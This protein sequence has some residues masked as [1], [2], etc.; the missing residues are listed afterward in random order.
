MTTMGKGSA[1]SGA[2]VPAERQR[3]PLPFGG[4]M[5]RQ[6]GVMI[7]EPSSFEYL[8][9]VHLYAGKAELRRGID[10]VSSTFQ[11]D[12]GTAMTHILAG[13]ALQSRNI[14]IIVGYES[15]GRTLHVFS[16]NGDLSGTPRY[17][18]QWGDALSVDA[19]DP[20]AIIAVE[21]NECVFLAHAEPQLFLRQ[22]TVYYDL[23][24]VS[25]KNMT[26]DWAADAG[27]D[28][29]IRFSGVMT[30]LDYLIGWGFGTNSEDH[31]EYVR[32]SVPQDQKT[33]EPEHFWMV[34]QRGVPV[35]CCAE[36][37]GGV[38]AMQK[39]RSSRLVG[40]SWLDFGLVTA[41]L[42]FG[43][44]G[45]RLAINYEGELYVWTLEGLRKT[46][47]GP[48]GDMAAPLDLRGEEP[49]DV[50]AR[51]GDIVD[52]FCYYLPRRAELIWQFGEIAYVLHLHDPNYPRLSYRDFGKSTYY[53]AFTLY[54]G[55][56]SLTPDIAPTSYPEFLSADPGSISAS[57][58]WANHG[59]AEF[60][61]IFIREAAA[62]GNPA[63]AW[64]KESTA[65]QS[66]TE[67]LYALM[68]VL[69]PDTLYDVALRFRVGDLIIPGYE[70]ADPDN[71]TDDATVD[72]TPADSKGQF[73]TDTFTAPSIDS[74]AWSRTSATAEKVHLV[75]TP[76]DSLCDIRLE[77]DGTLVTTVAAGTHGGEA[78]AVDDIS[79][80]DPTDFAG[81][82]VVH[83]VATPSYDGTDFSASGTVGQ[84]T[85]PE[86]APYDLLLTDIP[87][88]GYTLDWDMT[89]LVNG[90]EVYRDIN[91][92]SGFT[93]LGSPKAA[94]YEDPGG[95][96]G[97]KYKVRAKLHTY[98]VDDYSEFS[99]QVIAT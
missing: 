88:G 5:D 22:S 82:T 45:P 56:S 27:S 43:C 54:G 83:Y 69:Q 74:T 31:P 34:G 58:T 6:T 97:Y 47:G 96:V 75:I 26:A 37:L 3:I 49:T 33:F 76:A 62:D 13:V 73:T 19:K 86:P 36:S 25:L 72:G 67:Q 52:G 70:D 55:S 46:V 59:N 35:Q 80:G 79:D 50:K 14:G 23:A 9:N 81:E 1:Q 15:A 84:Y 94:T 89:Y 12:G 24:S 2:V 32:V 28:T 91:D 44:A 30:Y 39:T 21:G 53:C 98:T 8:W 40:T 60:V 61:D 4:G 99:S 18:Q 66:V 10:P 93:W 85:G 42:L 78:F 7:I 17:I 57:I 90:Y 77:R 20:P 41:D 65:F 92:G 87:A 38:V 11:T 16:V 51:R 48:F 68:L 29:N 64:T 71:W 63:G 95:N